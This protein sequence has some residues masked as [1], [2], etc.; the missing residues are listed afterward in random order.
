MKIII[1]K[2]IKQFEARYINM[3]KTIEKFSDV[4]TKKQKF[5]QNKNLISI[6]NIGINKKNSN[7]WGLFQ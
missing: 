1:K 4:E 3:E 5:H 2:I 6:K 7:H